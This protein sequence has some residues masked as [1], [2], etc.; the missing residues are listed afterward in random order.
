[1]KWSHPRLQ[2]D[3]SR[4]HEPPGGEDGVQIPS[5][6]SSAGSKELFCLMALAARVIA[7]YLPLLNHSFHELWDDG[8]YITKN[9]HVAKGLTAEGAGWA[10]P[11]RAACGA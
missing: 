10:T 8:T 3:E 6:S 9:P 4:I 7:L 5:D 11:P 2:Y 1:M